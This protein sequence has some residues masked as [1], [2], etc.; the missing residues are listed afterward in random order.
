MRLFFDTSAFLKR[1]I[2]EP[3]SIEVEELCK[4]AEDVAVS[5]LFPI[6]AVSALSRL[7]STKVITLSDKRRIK[8]NLFDDLRDITI[9][10]L[11]LSTVAFSIRTIESSAIKTLDAA[12]V[13]CAMEFKPDFFVSSDK[14][15]TA[16]AHAAGLRVKL[17]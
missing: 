9:I 6:E 14:Q 15:Q 16:A 10:P 8:K 5:M 11:S 7:F 13:G 3:G 12:H 1:Y 4:Q 17:I 2:E